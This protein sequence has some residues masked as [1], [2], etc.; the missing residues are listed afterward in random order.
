MRQVPENTFANAKYRFDA[1]NAKRG[2]VHRYQTSFKEGTKYYG[3]EIRSCVDEPWKEDK[4]S[5]YVFCG[6]EPEYIVLDK[7]ARIGQF[8][9][10]AL[11]EAIRDLYHF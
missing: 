3:A 9:P 6:D 4:Y 10:E 7:E 1:Y 5:V 8:S 2:R 11:K